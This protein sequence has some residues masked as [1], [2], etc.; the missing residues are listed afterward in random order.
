MTADVCIWLQGNFSEGVMDRVGTLERGPGGCS[1]LKCLS[2]R[3][4]VNLG[5]EL[6]VVGWLVSGFTGSWRELFLRNLRLVARLT[7]LSASSA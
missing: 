5:D 4:V 7:S 6:Q 2:S 1:S 3:F